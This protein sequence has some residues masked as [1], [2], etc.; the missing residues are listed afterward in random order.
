MQGADGLNI[1]PS[2]LFEDCLHLCAVFAYD[3]EI[4]APCLTG[5]AFGI[6]YVI[7]TEF[8]ETVRGEQHF[9]RAVVSHEDFRPVHH[10]CGNESKGV[11]AQFQRIAFADDH[12]SVFKSGAEKVCHHFE[13]FVG[14]N[15]DCLRIGL[16]KVHDIGGMIRLHVLHHQIIRLSA[17]QGCGMEILQ[18]FISLGALDVSGNPVLSFVFRNS[19]YSGVFAMVGGLALVPLVGL[20]TAKTRPSNVDETFSCYSENKTVGITDHLGK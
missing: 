19:I 3:A 16:H 5:P 18:L 13:R 1:E 14:R 11:S 17:P 10:G 8:S 9:V 20:F 2:S 4:V 15:D 6:D 12:S 7:G